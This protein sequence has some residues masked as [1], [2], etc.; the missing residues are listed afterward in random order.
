M[1]ILL[2]FLV[3]RFLPY[4]PVKSVGFCEHSKNKIWPW[5]LML[6]AHLVHFLQLV[7]MLTWLIFSCA[8]NTKS[9][10]GV[11]CT[12]AAYHK[13]PCWLC[14]PVTSINQLACCKHK[15]SPWCPALAAVPAFLCWLSPAF[16][17]GPGSPRLWLFS[18]PP[19]P[20]VLHSA[21][22]SF[23][24]ASS[25]P[26]QACS[27]FLLSPAPLLQVLTPSGTSMGKWINFQPGQRE[28]SSR[29]V[30]MQ[31][32]WQLVFVL[33]VWLGQSVYLLFMLLGYIREWH[34]MCDMYLVSN[35]PLKASVL[36][37]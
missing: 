24:P 37:V 13:L 7:T 33:G 29:T 17:W 22:F 2:C 21:G 28:W 6:A 35:P 11:Q 12:L 10:L 9:H 16:G 4:H 18:P 31:N 20:A 19:A 5:W 36:G 15:I 27:C 8:A 34:A 1:H 14:L 32:N 30:F 25:S 3:L 23:P 26:L